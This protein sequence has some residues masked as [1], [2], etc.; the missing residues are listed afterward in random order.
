L[1]PKT[2]LGAAFILLSLFTDAHNMNG[3]TGAGDRG[4]YFRRL[5][6]SAWALR[7]WM[8]HEFGINFAMHFGWHYMNDGDP[9]ERV[10]AM[11]S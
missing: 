3:E 8:K 6:R 10:A 11:L 9:T 2:P 7:R 5:E 4:F 1:T